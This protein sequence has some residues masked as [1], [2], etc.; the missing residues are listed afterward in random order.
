MKQIIKRDWKFFLTLIISLLALLMLCNYNLKISD[1][2]YDYTD[3][4]EAKE[5]IDN[6][7]SG[8]TIKQSFIAKQNNLSKIYIEFE[9]YKNEKNIGGQ[10]VIGIRDS[11]KLIKE[12]KIERNYIRENSVYK[13]E[14]PIQANSQGKEYSIYINFQND[15]DSSEKIYS[16]KY[17]RNNNDKFFINEKGVNGTL[18]IQEFYKNDKHAMFFYIT[19]IVLTII[20]VGISVFVYYKKSITPEKVFLYTV[21][22]I[23]VFYLLAIPVF[24]G[25]DELYHWNRAYEV[26]VGNLVTP[27]SKE[28][29]QGSMVSKGVEGLITEDWTQITYNDMI[30]DLDIKLDKNEKVLIDPAT[31]ALYS[32]VQYLPHSVGIALTRMITDMPILMAYGAKLFNMIFTI[33]LLYIAIKIV[34]FGKKLFLIPAYIPIAIEGFT[35]ISADG[36][37]MGIAFLFI[38]YVLK[39]AFGSIESIK[40]KDKILL[41]IIASVLALCKIVYLPLVLLV[42]IIPKEKF[43]S[44]TNKEK[45]ING[46]LICAIAGI[47]NLLWL[48]YA[49]RYLSAFR[50]GDSTYQILEA[51]K[52]PIQ[53]IE[54]VLHT[55]NS[56]ADKYVISAFGGELGWGELININAFMPYIIAC[57]YLIVSFI[58]E[59]VKDRFKNYQVFIIV[60]VAIAIIGLVFTSLYVQWTAVGSTSILGVQGRYFIPIMPLIAI[61]IGT[62]SKIVSKYKEENIVKFIG[63]TGIL[64][65]IYVIL[66]IVICHI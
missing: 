37:T 60:L 25:H 56:N 59:T 35:T 15:S 23:C 13:F 50:D 38:A 19:E 8:T 47:L 51:I 3:K 4:I 17:Q 7:K 1:K 26:S 45:I 9:P 11:E 55:V 64:I 43:K 16:V 22:I 52:N 5:S 32:F 53:Y 41:A 48:W 36:L 57:M 10:A 21:P 63:I 58:D 20:A 24:K 62:C 14:F 54:M 2:L 28:N 42:F 66:T 61:I 31:A 33:I 27:I 12:I 49:G 29:V 34:P 44:R 30:E 65:Q 46:V 18:A 6:I 40:S 39:L